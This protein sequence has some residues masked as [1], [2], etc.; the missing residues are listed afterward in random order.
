MTSYHGG[1]QKI[2]KG[3]AETISELTQGAKQIKGY[4]EPFCGMLG[5]YQHIPFV[6]PF[7][8]GRKKFL[9]GDQNKSVIYMWKKAQRGW[10]PP[11][12]CSEK[13][14]EE[15]KESNRPSAE[16]GFIGH[17]YSYGGQYFKG[18]RGKYQNERTYPEAAH[19]VRDIAEDLE[20]VTFSHG[21]YRQFNRLKGYVIY[22]DP[23]YNSASYYNENHEMT[24]FD[25]DDFW[26][27]CVS[28]A[29]NNIVFV[30]EYDLPKI[31]YPME[32]VYK[33]KV[34]ITGKTIKDGNRTELLILLN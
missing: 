32:V 34:K 10:I 20:D 22:C 33:K 29:Q 25:K 30:S 5:V 28:M 15:L 8:E 19:K 9:A 2:G 27:W 12:K 23:P 16:K 6:E 13:K 18:Y 14:Y 31:N 17:Q 21:D 11:L 26:D 1:K 4:C 7:N 3:I 24:S